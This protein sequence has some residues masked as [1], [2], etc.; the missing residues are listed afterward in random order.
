MTIRKRLP[1]MELSPETEHDYLMKATNK[2]VSDNLD[3]LRGK[4]NDLELIKRRNSWIKKLLK[5]KGIK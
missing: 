3:Y 2:N 5:K 1:I 4:E